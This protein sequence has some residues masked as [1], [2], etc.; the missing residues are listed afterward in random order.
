[1]RSAE[2]TLLYA[3]LSD[4]EESYYWNSHLSKIKPFYLEVWRNSPPSACSKS[5]RPVTFNWLKDST[6]EEKV[7]IDKFVIT[8][9]NEALVAL[10]TV[11]G[12]VQFNCRLAAHPSSPCCI[13]TST[14]NKLKPYP[15][16]T[17]KSTE[18]NT[19]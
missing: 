9:Y 7:N 13:C 11:Y 15:W 14:D 2:A 16:C 6:L 3:S 17:G 1:M 19:W 5:F 10:L 18:Q 12:S 4:S 8:D